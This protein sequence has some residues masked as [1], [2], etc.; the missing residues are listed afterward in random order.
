MLESVRKHPIIS[1]IFACLTL[2]GTL[3]PALSH[4]TALEL[5]AQYGWQDMTPDLYQWFLVSI[6][7]I[8]IIVVMVIAFTIARTNQESSG[9]S[10]WLRRT[11][12]IFPALVL[13]LAFFVFGVGAF[14]V[15]DDRTDISAISRDIACDSVQ[16]LPPSAT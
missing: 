16:R 11:V 14:T 15:H 10:G 7:L 1:T 4:K 3:W 9:P 8:S 6:N 12:W 13:V 2:V 5:F